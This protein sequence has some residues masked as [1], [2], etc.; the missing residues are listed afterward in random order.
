MSAAHTTFNERKDNMNKAK[1]IPVLL[2]GLLAAPVFAQTVAIEAQRNVNQ[3]TRIENGLKSGALTTREAAK[4]EHQEA[5]IDS[6]EA[7]A[8]KDGKLSNAE[9]TRIQRMQNQ[10]SRDIAKQE[11]DGQKGNPTSASSLR[12][13]ADVQRNINQQ[14][15]VKNGVKDGSLTRHEAAK[16]EQGQAKVDRQEARAGRDGHVGAAEEK[17]IQRSE[18]RQSRRIHRQRHDAQNG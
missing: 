5:R 14:Q 16:L 7:K 15:R 6:A 3:E 11:H 8:L 1:L 4:L 17:Q 12:M 2:A 13:Q 9:K 10:A 18:N